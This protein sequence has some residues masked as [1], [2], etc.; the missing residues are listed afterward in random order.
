[1]YSLRF[2]AKALA[3]LIAL[4]IIQL[5]LR[6]AAQAP[7]GETGAAETGILRLQLLGPGDTA[8][9]DVRVEVAGQ[10]H[11]TSA[12]GA[13]ELRVP[14]G[15]QRVR[16]AVPH[17]L[18][19]EVPTDQDVW[20][21]DLPDIPVIGGETTEVKVTLG[22]S[23]AVLG[24]DLRAPEAG[25][26]TRSMEREF[27]RAAAAKPKGTV[28]GV[29][30]AE[31]HGGT[32]AEARVYVRGVPVEAET[33]RDGVFALE[34]P[35][36]SYQVSVIHP[37]Y[38]TE[39][40][41]VAVAGAKTRDLRIE[42]SPRSAELEELVVMGAHIEGGIAS[43]IQERKETTAVSDV[44]G[45]EQMTRVGA[46]NAAAAL[47]RVTGLTV[48][49][50][51]F[52]IVRGMG[53]RYSSLML[54]RL[55]VPS[56]E[57]TRRVVPLDLFPTGV[58]ESVVVQKSYSPDMP[59]EFGGGTVQLRTRGYPDK[60]IANITLGTGYN[61]QTHLRQNIG[62]EGG[63]FDYLGFDDGTRALP[64]S[65]AHAGKIQP[66]GLFDPEGVNYT[67]DQ[68][69][70][71]AS[72]LPSNYDVTKSFTPPDLTI[73]S[74]IGNRFD[75]RHAKIGFV[76]AVG[77][78]NQYQ[79]INDQ[80]VRTVG[81]ANNQLEII[82][83][84]KIDNMMRT[85][86][87]SGF[88]DWGVEFSKNHV[89]KFTS[90]LLRQSEDTTTV[91]TGFVE[92]IGGDARRTRLS[93]LERQ[94]LDQQASGKHVFPALNDLQADWR[95]SY[96]RATRDEPDRRDYQYNAE[97]E[98]G[99]YVLSGRAGD[100]QRLFGD[101]ADSTH[102]GDLDLTQP[103]HIWS[104]LKAK[105]KAGF[106]IYHRERT[107]DVRRFEFA[108]Q[109]LADDVR[110]LSPG[111]VLTADRVGQGLSFLETTLDNDSYD[112]KMRLE[113][114]YGM[115][116]L[117]LFKWLELMAGARVEHAGIQASTVDQFAP[118]KPPTYAKLNNLD[119]LPAATA[120][121]RLEDVQLRGTYSRT[122]N[123]P[124][125]RELSP[126]KYND[127]ETNA[128]LVGNE[129]L[130]RATID[131]FDARLEW[132]LTTDEVFSFGGFYKVFHDPIEATIVPAVGILYSYLNSPSAKV[133]GLELEGRK[134]FSFIHSKLEA[135][136][137]AG[138]L[139]LIKSQVDLKL[140]NGESTSRP[141]QSQSPWVVN[142]Q[143]GYDN[144]GE[145]GNG[146]AASVLYNVAGRRIRYVGV[147]ADGIPDQYEQP[148]HQLDLVVS[149]ALPHGFNLGFRAQNLINPVQKWKQGD[150][151][152]R[153]F[154]RGSY[155]AL[156]LAWSY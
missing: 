20:I 143:F 153:R 126:S 39:S 110:A 31:E 43:L 152:V 29:V 137:L 34:L 89:L 55:Q 123:R 129:N 21:V 135:L 99:R 93:W 116:E 144:T 141:L 66:R 130:K 139:A 98:T 113:A 119:V 48:V 40:T 96:A 154:Q 64:R 50:G 148:F 90:M 83:D 37:E 6:A 109:Q 155:Y 156:T 28:R 63:K 26:G 105:A 149:Q 52:V 78:R 103:I 41:N 60:L 74:S 140:E 82:D 72:E 18:L 73:V 150:I 79:A 108:V 147:P 95:Y 15:A 69:K 51:K 32:V 91:R 75:L 145:G 132:Y 128:Q 115:L 58:L 70:Q 111:Q 27:Q 38:G 22:A 35:E 101:L 68:I 19:P 16:L 9:G 13:A 30:T 84:F 112:A 97:P 5:G 23:G 14:E 44:I 85:V 17:A 42:L 117:P 8:L 138:N 53:E 12:E 134:R 57:P 54:N 120:T 102:E 1:M 62:Y 49:D 3:S 125:L 122:L 127:I 106:M 45:A 46:T 86:S 133:M 77:Y 33:G 7:E 4:A 24:M 11:N 146:L 136:Y 92:D 81:A 80:I 25:G 142:A 65:I 104:G 118:D 36:G 151:V 94:I 67:P 10:A 56:P 2:L 124:D 114:G 47:S 100:N 88:L 76:T 59:G 61:S 71:F 87:L 121:L 107:S 131:N